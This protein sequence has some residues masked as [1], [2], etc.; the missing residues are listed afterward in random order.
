MTVSKE[1]LTSAFYEVYDERAPSPDALPDVTLSERFQNRMERL[2]RREA[3]HP[4]A[5]RHPTAR[6]LLIAA[7][8][9]LLLFA[10]AM[11]VSAIRDPIIKFFTVSHP[12]HDNVFFAPSDRKEIEHYYTVTA[13]PEGFTLEQ[14]TQIEGINVLHYRDKHGYFIMLK[15]EIPHLN[16]SEAIDNE[17]IKAERTEIDG[18]EVLFGFYADD[19]LFLWA[20]DGYAFTLGISIKGLTREQAI[21]IYKS[22][23]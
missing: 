10:L 11:S 21:D 9:L 12:G 19:A 13:L 15:Q 1:T 7:V 22:V 16:S 2:I 5:V 6:A 23:K 20:D 8:I 14:N 4:W 18:Q 17:D 3:A